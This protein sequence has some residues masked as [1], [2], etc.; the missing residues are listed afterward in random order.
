L[1]RVARTGQFR[2]RL[3]DEILDECFKS[4]LR[5][6]PDLRIASLNRTRQ[7]I[8]EAVPDL[9]VRNYSRLI[10]GLELPDPNDRHVLA[11]A[12]R[13]G[14]QTIVTF[15]LKD[16]PEATLAGYDIVARHP[17]EFML[18][19]LDASPAVVL[20]VLNEQTEALRAPPMTVDQVLARLEAGGMKGFVAR[21]RT[22]RAGPAP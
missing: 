10:G 21:V 4:I 6:R 1:L 20:T 15:N 19:L 18:E 22:L 11:A 17:D 14:A 16:F 3:T 5:E 12:I 8:V 2:A 9:V 7:L 13:S